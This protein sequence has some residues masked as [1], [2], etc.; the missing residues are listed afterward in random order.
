VSEGP[1]RVLPQDDE[2][3]TAAEFQTQDLLEKLFA[4]WGPIYAVGG[5]LEQESP[6]QRIAGP[7]GTL[8]MRFADMAAST[9]LAQ[10]PPPAL[11]AARGDAAL[12]VV[13]AAGWI[14]RLMDP[15]L[16]R[17]ICDL[18]VEQLRE[19]AGAELSAP[20]VPAPEGLPLTPLRTSACNINLGGPGYY[21]LPARL[22]DTGFTTW[23][24][25]GA[26][27]KAALAAGLPIKVHLICPQHP[28]I[29]LEVDT[30]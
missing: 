30:L 27:A 12:L 15:R 19:C 6:R 11:D 17:R 2:A 21:D 5:A 29:R 8:L 25:P 16:R 1:F 24:A 4:V 7:I 10:E 23:W 28:G 9:F 22:D 3:V 20:T 26:E 13:R 18:A 14:I